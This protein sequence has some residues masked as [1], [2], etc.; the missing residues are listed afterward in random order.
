MDG[1]QLPQGYR[2][3]SRRQFSFYHE[4]SRNSWH[5]FDQPRKDERLSQPWSHPVVT[6]L[7]AYHFGEEGCFSEKY[8][9]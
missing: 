9:Y 1:V 4:V 3:T 2:A 6:L 8:F 5:S 7:R